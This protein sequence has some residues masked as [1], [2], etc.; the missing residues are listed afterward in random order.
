MLYQLFAVQFA[1]VGIRNH[2]VRGGRTVFGEDLVELP[3]QARADQNVVRGIP[4]LDERDSDRYHATS[5]W[6]VCMFTARARTNSKSESRLRYWTM[7]GLIWWL[8][9]R[10]TTDRSARRQTVRAT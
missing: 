5:S 6:P 9:A 7:S 3:D 4:L 2:R 8:R 10:L 1:D